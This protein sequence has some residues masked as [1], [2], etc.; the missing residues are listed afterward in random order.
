MKGF[1]GSWT[2]DPARVSNLFFQT[3]LAETWLPVQNRVE[4]EYSLPYL[5]RIVSILDTHR[6]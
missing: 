3:L 4:P 1:N 6:A 2:T 5:V